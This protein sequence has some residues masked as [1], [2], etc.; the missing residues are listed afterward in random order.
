MER[1]SFPY[2]GAVLLELGIKVSFCISRKWVFKVSGEV[3]IYDHAISM[4]ELILGFCIFCSSFCFIFSWFYLANVLFMT[5]IL[6]LFFR[7][8]DVDVSAENVYQPPEEFVEDKKV[9]LVDLDVT[10]STE[11]WLIQWPVNQV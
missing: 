4:F 6:Y 10:E 2:I 9:P 1:F 11:L 8:M 3:Y 7:A 5:S